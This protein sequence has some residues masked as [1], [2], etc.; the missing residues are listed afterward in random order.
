MAFHIDII[1]LAPP[2]GECDQLLNWGWRIPFS[3]ASPRRIGWDPARNSERFLSFC[4]VFQKLLNDKKIERAP[5]VEVVQEQPK[6]ILLSA[7]GDACGQQVAVL[8]FT[9]FIFAYGVGPR[10]HVARFHPNRGAGGLM[11][12][13]VSIP[14]FGHISDR[15]GRGT[16]TLLVPR[17]ADM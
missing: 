3:C 5:I 4:P 14:G 12:S 1:C 17:F 11:R 2:I 10:A 7:D 16:C 13:F 8:L 15:I 9:A 6:E